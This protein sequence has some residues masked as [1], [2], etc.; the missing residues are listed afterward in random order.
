LRKLTAELELKRSQLALALAGPK[1]AEA[2]EEMEA[3]AGEP[4]VAAI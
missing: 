4:V 1:A 3:A 2:D